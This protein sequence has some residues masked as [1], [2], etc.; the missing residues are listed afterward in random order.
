MILVISLLVY[1]SLANDLVFCLAKEEETIHKKKVTGP[2]YALNQSIINKLSG[3]GMM[4]FKKDFVKEVCQSQTFTPSLQFL[5]SI[6]SKDHDDVLDKLPYYV[7]VSLEGEYDSLMEFS[8][9]ALFKYLSDLQSNFKEHNC[10][11]KEMPLIKE[12]QTNQKYLES[13]NDDSFWT[14]KRTKEIFNK[15]KNIDYILKKCQR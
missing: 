14:E 10:L 3:L 12:M 5:K 11:E 15:L 8:R 6:L 1:C 7:N 13:E 2:V 4:T 9:R